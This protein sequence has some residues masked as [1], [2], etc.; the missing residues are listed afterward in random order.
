MSEMVRVVEASLYSKVRKVIKSGQTK[1][2]SQRYS[3]EIYTI[4]HVIKPK[5][6]H[7]DFM[8]ERY[9][10]KYSDGDDV[11]TEYKINDPNKKREPKLFYG[12]ELLRVV[13]NR[14]NRKTKDINDNDAKLINNIEPADA[15]DEIM[16]PR[17]SIRTKT[18]NKMLFNNV[19]DV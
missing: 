8:K 15:N 3:S 9:F 14:D 10:L 7:K 5:G 19:Y 12:S 1:L 2:L 16:E 17:K 6:E 18:K 11:L 13:E 4:Y